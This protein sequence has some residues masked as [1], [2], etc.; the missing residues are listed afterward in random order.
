MI[1]ITPQPGQPGTAAGVVASLL[2]KQRLPRT[3]TLTWDNSK[4]RTREIAGR[5]QQHEAFG[6]Y[7][8][9]GLIALDTGEGFHALSELHHVYDLRGSYSISWHDE[10][11]EE[12]HAD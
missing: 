4:T 1:M 3:F 8:P 6:C 9:N 5:M 11:G 7:F 12:H 10:E 2:K